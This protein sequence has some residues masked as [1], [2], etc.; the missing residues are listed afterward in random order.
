MFD[1][2]TTMTVKTELETAF[3]MEATDF[4]ETSVHIYQYVRHRNWEF[5]S[6]SHTF[7]TLYN[8]N[9]VVSELTTKIA[10]CIMHF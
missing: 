5:N 10:Y 8:H 3:T 2:L 7:N 9:F 6:G 4:S 1:V